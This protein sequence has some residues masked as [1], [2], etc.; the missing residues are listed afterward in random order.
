[1][2]AKKIANNI[3]LTKPLPHSACKPCS[4]GNFQTEPYRNK[5]ELGLELLDLVHNNVTGSFIKELYGG[6][7]FDTL[8]CDATKRSKVVF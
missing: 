7:H 5:I 2:L 4:I 6:T 3:D 8:F 1:M